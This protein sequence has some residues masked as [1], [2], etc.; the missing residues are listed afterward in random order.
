MRS[1]VNYCFDVR[2]QRPR[3]EQI[4][5]RMQTIAFQEKLKLSKEQVDE[6]IEASNHD[7]RQT[8]Y[9]LQLLSMGGNCGEIQQKDCAVNTFEAARRILSADTSMMEKQEMFF[10]DY[11]II[12]LLRAIVEPLNIHWEQMLRAVLTTVHVIVNSLFCCL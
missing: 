8:I 10:T 4:R 6:V 3:V 2:F 7:V 1:L 5:S 9:N 11:T 12:P